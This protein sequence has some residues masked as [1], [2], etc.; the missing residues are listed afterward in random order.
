MGPIQAIAVFDSFTKNA[1]NVH[2]AIDNPRVIK[3]GFLSEIARYLFVQRDR[4]RI[5]GLVPSTNRKALKLDTHIGF[6]EVTRIPNAL[7]EGIDY[8][9]LELRREDCRWL[10]QERKVA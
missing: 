7:A 2:L 10:D 8:V 9:V 4:T 1:C 5:F 6:T 3:Y